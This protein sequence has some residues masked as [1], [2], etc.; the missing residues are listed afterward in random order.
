MESDCVFISKCENAL[1]GTALLGAEL[2]FPADAAPLL[3]V[4]AF[5]LAVSAFAATVSAL[6]EGVNSADPVS[7]LDP[8]DV[9]PLPEELAGAPTLVEAA[10]AWI[11]NLFS[12]SGST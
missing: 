11:Y 10:F 6:F 5:V 3:D 9:E 7:A 4:L 8:A 2:V 12:L 1:S